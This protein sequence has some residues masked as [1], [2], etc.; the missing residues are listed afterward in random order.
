M[1]LP[2]ILSS[3]ISGHLFTLTGSYDALATVT[4]PSGGASS[5]TFSAIPQTGYKHLQ[6]RAISNA[7][8]SLYMSFN[9][10]TTATN[11]YSHW[12]YGNGSTTSASS[13]NSR[14]A[15][16]IGTSSSGIFSGVIYDILDY[17]NTNK[18]KTSRISVGWDANGSGQVG[19][20]SQL[21]KNTAAISSITIEAASGAGFSQY[22]QFALYGVK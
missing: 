16:V 7:T 19:L 11:Y 12:V 21:W 2:G 6:I 5:I 14:L 13:Q 4:V 3:Q 8:D 22:S 18:Y 9:A 15:P 10:D 20:T 17:A 1:I